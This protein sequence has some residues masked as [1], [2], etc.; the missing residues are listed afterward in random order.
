MAKYLFM[1]KLRL[2][3]FLDYIPL[4]ILFGF[5]INLCWT[6]TTTEIIFVWMNVT[7]LIILLINIVLFFWNHKAGV[8]GLGATLILGFFELISFEPGTTTFR[9]SKDGISEGVTLH[10]QISYL[11]WI[12]IHLIISHKYYFGIA[13]KKYWE[14]FFDTQN[15]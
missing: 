12:A 15:S 5:A 1:G 10:I 11:L 6:L 2:K 8:L 13:T 4:L 9:L 14:T 3:H 7:G